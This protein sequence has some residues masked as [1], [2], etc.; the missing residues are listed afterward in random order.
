MHEHKEY[1]LFVKVI[2][3]LECKNN[4]SFSKYLIVEKKSSSAYEYSTSSPNNQGSN[5]NPNNS[6]N[7][8]RQSPALIF[9]IG[10]CSARERCWG[11]SAPLRSFT[12]RYHFCHWHGVTFFCTQRCT[13]RYF[14]QVKRHPSYVHR[15]ARVT[16]VH[17][18]LSASGFPLHL[19]QLYGPPHVMLASFTRYPANLHM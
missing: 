5:T 11:S 9:I 3:I 7:L 16:A 14:L 13:R 1:T 19:R 18:H 17:Q 6:N 10:H 15:C 12:F 4:E 8:F 2:I